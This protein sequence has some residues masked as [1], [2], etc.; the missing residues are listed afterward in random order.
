MSGRRFIGAVVCE[1][2]GGW[3]ADPRLHPS[4][5]SGDTR[6]QH[7]CTRMRQRQCAQLPSTHSERR[8]T[9]VSSSIRS[10]P[11]AASHF[12]VVVRAQL[13]KGRHSHTPC[14][15]PQQDRTQ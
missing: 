6:V 11:I 3:L 7:R 13:C 9:A 4:R 15:M 12:P 8:A 2:K 14:D 5:L 1:R 10:A